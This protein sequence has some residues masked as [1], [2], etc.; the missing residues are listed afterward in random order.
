[1]NIQK[2][3]SLLAISLLS[4]PAMAGWTRLSKSSIELRGDIEKNSY[5]EYL[6]VANG[7]FSKVILHSGGGYPSVALRIAENIADR[8]GVEIKVDGACLS[9][10]ANY[11]ALA[12]SRLDVDCHSV[13]GFH[14]TL[15]SA[16]DSVASLK[17]E[18]APQPLI[19]EYAKWVALFHENEDIFYNKIGVDRKIIDDSVVV[20]K[21]IDIS[22]SYSIDRDSGEYSYTTT[23]GV[24][25]PPLADLESYGLRNINYCKQYTSHLV[26]E[27]FKKNQISVRYS[28][29]SMSDGGD[30]KR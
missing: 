9:A 27:I 2:I 21:R 22:V 26:D 20:I 25:I 6:K 15:P 3:A 10:C 7:E 8:K 16:G 4:F 30:V 14:G 1:M 23:A 13:L 19:D 11:L 12:G 29:S 5:N 24:W 28:I 17:Q 18:G